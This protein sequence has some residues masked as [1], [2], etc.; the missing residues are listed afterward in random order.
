MDKNTA[1]DNSAGGSSALE[2][3]SHHSIIVSD[4]ADF[5]AIKEFSPTDATTNPTLVLQAVSNPKY[6]HILE[7]AVKE[8][9]EATKGKPTDVVLSVENI[10]VS[11]C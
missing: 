3:L 7:K 5:E 6:K 4:S 1:S 8:A 2:Q 10:C 9:Q 11:V